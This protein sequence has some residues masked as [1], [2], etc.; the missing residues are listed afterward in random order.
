[1]AEQ[2]GTHEVG[3]GWVAR[4]PSVLSEPDIISV[5]ERIA[6]GRLISLL[7]RHKQ[8]TVE[9]LATRADVDAAEI[10]SIEEHVL[11]E[12]DARTVYRLAQTFGLSQQK[13]MELAGLGKRESSVA[14][15][16][17]R[18]AARSEAPAKLTTGERAAI[19]A[20]LVDLIDKTE[21]R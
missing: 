15:S 11:F 3:A 5:G 1:M 18:F 16:A 14:E 19:D 17:I 9:Q 12:P 4:D 7:R 6:F 2:E 13:L 8:Y 20:F 21:G 10:L